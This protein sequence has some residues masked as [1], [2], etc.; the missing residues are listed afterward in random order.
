MTASLVA[1]LQALP[2]AG[3]SL[4]ACDPLRSFTRTAEGRRIVVHVPN[5]SGTSRHGAPVRRTHTVLLTIGRCSR[6]ARLRP[7]KGGSRGCKRFHCA[8]EIS[9]R[10]STKGYSPPQWVQPLACAP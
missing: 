4:G 5:R 7:R 1:S 8:S 2:P 10:R 3:H 6:Y 9:S